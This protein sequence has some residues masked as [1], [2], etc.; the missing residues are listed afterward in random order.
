VGADGHRRIDEL[1]SFPGEQKGDDVM[2]RILAIV[3]TALTVVFCGL[4]G[5]AL[6]CMGSFAGMGAFVPGAS[7]QST[8]TTQDL[9][10]GVILFVCGGV[11]MMIV[12][13]VVGWISFQVSKAGDL[14]LV[15]YE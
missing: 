7:D 8:G 9:F 4:P 6:F 11:L 2:T 1:V 15:K 3:F 12:P 14:P 13:V 10:N 5:L